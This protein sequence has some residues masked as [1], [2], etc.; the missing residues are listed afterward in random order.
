MAITFDSIGNGDL[1]EKFKIA[2]QQV[3]KNIMNPNMDP[4]AAREITVNIKFKPVGQGTLNIDYNVKPKLAGFKKAK[5]CSWLDR[6][7]E[8]GVLI[9]PN[10]EAD[11]PRLLRYRR[12]HRLHTRM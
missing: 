8:Q 7:S 1:A 3:G 12:S 10:R 9:C 2:L 4:D 6:M 5:P 11:F